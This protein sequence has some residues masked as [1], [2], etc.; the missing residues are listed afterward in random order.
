[1]V[2]K[3]KC[4]ICKVAEIWP[5]IQAPCSIY[6]PM[7]NLLRSDQLNVDE[8]NLL[9]LVSEKSSGNM[10]NEQRRSNGMELAVRYSKDDLSLLPAFNDNCNDHFEDFQSKRK[11]RKVDPKTNLLPQEV[12]AS[13]LLKRM[14]VL[15]LLVKQNEDN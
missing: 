13:P 12:L 3:C 11:R 1:M 6:K 15:A 4:P 14:A 5:E 9:R 8:M 7:S 2:E 10:P